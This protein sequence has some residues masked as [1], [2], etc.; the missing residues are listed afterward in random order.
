[1]SSFVKNNLSEEIQGLLF[2]ISTGEFGPQETL[3]TCCEH[4]THALSVTTNLNDQDDLIIDSNSPD[5]NQLDN[6]LVVGN[7]NNWICIYCTYENN[8]SSDICEMCLKSKL[9]NQN[10]ESIQIVNNDV[11]NNDINN[12]MWECLHC[13]FI[14]HSFID[15]CSICGKSKNDIQTNLAGFN[16]NNDLENEF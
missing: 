4:L 16:V 15:D 12:N 2:R 13:T 14:N 5:I 6:T 9:N 7:T 3:S 1:M 8:I 11:N 10:N